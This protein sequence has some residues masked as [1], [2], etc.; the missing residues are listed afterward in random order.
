MT[1]VTEL[2]TL[3]EIDLALDRDRARMAEIEE[4]I[5]ESEELIEARRV[6]AEKEDALAGFRAR[7]KDIEWE[8]DEVRSKASE[9]E[10]KLYGGTVRNPKELS[11]L[12]TDVRSLKGQASKREDA[13]LALMEEAEAAEAEFRAADAVYSEME[14]AFRSNREELLREK[15]GIEPEVERLRAQRAEQVAG[16]DRA[17]L[18]LYQLL[19]ERR[20]GQAVA[21]VER[22]MCQGCRITLPMSV[23]QKA[24]A[25]VGLVQC[26]SCERILLVN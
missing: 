17:T 22:G 6:R 12:D 5:Q 4:A 10:A 19:R 9:M 11:D 7:Q 13:L 14:A 16:I 23:L 18:G 3:Q 24:R 26:V 2:F 8:V 21:H 20:G 25:G 1:V 15:S